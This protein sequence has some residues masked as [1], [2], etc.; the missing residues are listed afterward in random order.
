[1]KIYADENIE[2]S[3]IEGLRR[4]GIE[5]VSALEYGYF[6]KADEFHLKKA[7]EIKAEILTHDTDFLKFA[8]C[9]LHSTR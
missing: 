6:G 4:R 1:M 3:I 2:S 5:V 8:P 7:S 9:S